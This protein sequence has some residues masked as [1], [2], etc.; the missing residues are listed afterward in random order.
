M[1]K[2]LAKKEK[3]IDDRMMAFEKRCQEYYKSKEFTID[4][5][6]EIYGLLQDQAI[7]ITGTGVN[8]VRLCT[9]YEVFKNKIEQ[10]ICNEERG[11]W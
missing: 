6:H 1:N 11:L 4:Q 3:E 2:K 7:S 8:A 10:L 9:I 5:L